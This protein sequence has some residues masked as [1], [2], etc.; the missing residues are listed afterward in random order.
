MTRA[1]IV[2]LCVCLAE[3][4][5]AQSA[6]VVGSLAAEIS[7]SSRAE[8]VG[9]ETPSGDGEV[10][11]GS[12]RA[13]TSLGDRWGVELEFAR[14][15]TSEQETTPNPRILQGASFTFS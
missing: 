6:Y 4:A 7:R 1:G 10:L 8:T 15:A 13:G 5:R 9:F 11:G 2:L 14:G 12:L 3:P